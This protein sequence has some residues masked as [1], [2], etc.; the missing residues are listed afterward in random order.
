M[1]IRSNIYQRLVAVVHEHV[2]PGWIVAES[3]ML[4]DSR[5]GQL[6]E[7]DVV[8]D[9]S[10][11]GYP[12]LVGIEARDRG[13]VADVNWV[14]AMA[15]KHDD[16]P[17]NML[18]LWSSTGFSKNAAAKAEALRI[19]TVKSKTLADAPW[20]CLAQTFNGGS[21]KWV[22]PKFELFVDVLLPCGKAVRWPASRASI[23]CRRRDRAELTIGAILAHV[24]QSKE[25]QTAMLNNATDGENDF[26]GI[27]EPP[28]ECEVTS[29]D[30][31]TAI[32]KRVII[33]LKTTT[34]V[35]P[36]FLRTIVHDDVATSLGELKVSDGALRVVMREPAVGDPVVRVNHVRPVQ[37]RRPR[38]DR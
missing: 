32:L 30:G 7:V 31:A 10:A 33:G 9:G 1:P 37:S 20:A 16:L 8:L 14:E 27:Y 36:V 5:T 3:R 4:K 23:L 18:V 21:M 11:A 2:G 35:R 25:L 17:T 6:R 13:R 38:N 12:I 29:S 19:I 22:R 24:E 26:H 28:E 34:E 15:K